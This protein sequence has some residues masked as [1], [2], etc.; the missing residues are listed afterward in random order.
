[1]SGG[2][3]DGRGEA[4]ARLLADLEKKSNEHRLAKV[5]ANAAVLLHNS[6]NERSQKVVG[7]ACLKAALTGKGMGECADMAM[8]VAVSSEHLLAQYESKKAEM[9]EK[10]AEI[11]KVRR[12]I[13]A[14]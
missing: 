1:M 14:L 10:A 3:Q 6:L 4:R 2:A 5:Q 11:E 9:E 8:K 7:A 12:E 13:D